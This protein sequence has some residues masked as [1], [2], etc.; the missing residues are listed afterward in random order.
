MKDINTLSDL[1]KVMYI[2]KGFLK[3]Y[4]LECSWYDVSSNE[5]ENSFEVNIQK[6]E[7]D[8][9]TRMVRVIMSQVHKEIYLYNIFIPH[10]DRGQ[11]IGMGL[12]NVLFQAAKVLGYQL[13][14]Y[15]MTDSFYAKMLER[16]ALPTNLPDCLVVTDDTIL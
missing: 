8:S 12:I 3:D 13:V 9:G 15:S 5:L 6:D 7:N 2:T 10:E 4:L 14:L 1:E 16:G 11:G